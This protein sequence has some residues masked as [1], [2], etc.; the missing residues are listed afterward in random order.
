[1]FNLKLYY[2]N[3]IFLSKFFNK[4]LRNSTFLKYSEC[5]V[6]VSI[7]ETEDIYKAEWFGG[8]SAE[9]KFWSDMHNWQ[10]ESLWRIKDEP[11]F[12]CFMTETFISKRESILFQ[13]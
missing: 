1:M 6:T 11:V 12:D 2:K 13:I 8:V 10:W 5:M 4:L 9:L 3:T 7:L